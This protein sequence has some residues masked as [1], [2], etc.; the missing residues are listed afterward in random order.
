MV[1]LTRAGLR[2]TATGLNRQLTDDERKAEFAH[3]TTEIDSLRVRAAGVGADMLAYL[4][5]SA[6]VEARMLEEEQG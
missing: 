1:E 3:L 4:L 6:S 5:A 2:M